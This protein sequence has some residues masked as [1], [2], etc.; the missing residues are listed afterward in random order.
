MNRLFVSITIAFFITTATAQDAE[1]DSLLT[2]LK[3]AK[4]DTNKT[5][6][7]RNIGVAYSNQDPRT[8]IAYWQQGVALSRK[9]NYTKGLARN[10]INIGTGY[11][12]LG[13]FDS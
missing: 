4:D 5:N 2:E 9:L 11:S 10:F 12:Y 13:K 3:T 1:L 7:L 6:L 8:A